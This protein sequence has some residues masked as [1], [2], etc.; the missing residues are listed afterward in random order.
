MSRKNDEFDLN[1]NMF[2]FLPHG[3]LGGHYLFYD[4]GAAS[5]VW[6]RKATAGAAAAPTAETGEC[7]LATA[8]MKCERWERDERMMR[9]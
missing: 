8:E 4:P 2:Q 9:D 5:C 3:A 1:V 7:F 6:D